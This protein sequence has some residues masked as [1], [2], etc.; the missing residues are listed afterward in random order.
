MSVYICKTHFSCLN[1]ISLQNNSKTTF[2]FVI[3]ITK[4]RLVDKKMHS[5]EKFS[6]L[7]ISLVCYLLVSPP[8]HLCLVVAGVISLVALRQVRNTTELLVVVHDLVF[9]PNTVNSIWAKE[10][11][12]SKL[13]YTQSRLSRL[14]IASINISLTADFYRKTWHLLAQNKACNLSRFKQFSGRK[15]TILNKPACVYSV[16]SSCAML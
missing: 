14:Y 9:S 1:L 5:C 12:G 11:K 6:S 3:N 7:W 15:S 2:S 8:L 16:L 13:I 10:G 4:C